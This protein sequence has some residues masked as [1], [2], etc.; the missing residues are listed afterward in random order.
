MNK[1]H[2][3][4][5]TLPLTGALAVVIILFPLQFIDGTP[6]LLAERL[7][8][9]GGYFQIMI[10]A[11]F[12]FFM[13]KNMLNPQKTGWWRR[14]SWTLFSAVFFG[15]LLLGI[16]VDRIF[17]MTGDLHLPVPAMIISGPVYRGELSVMTLI[18][19]SAVVLSGPAW[20]SQYCYFGAI[21]SAFAGRKT[22]SKKRRY[23]MTLK[24]TFLFLAAA[25]ALLLRLAGAERDTALIAGAITGGAGLIIIFI[26]SRSTGK[27]IHCSVWCPVGTLV[28]YLKYINPFRMKIKEGCSRCMK[29][30]SSC[31][32]DALAREDILALKPG[33]TCTL[34]GDCITTCHSSSIIYTFPGMK[35]LN[36]RRFYIT[37][38]VVI[39]SLVLAMARI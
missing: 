25:V 1:T 8:K 38:T 37:L 14:F 6:M 20:C 33:V 22:A 11:L 19:L 31:R 18:F 17:L 30:S 36:A 23:R 9:G 27:M 16:F 34:C 3:S 13:V 5:L 12:A 32:Y 35:P 15:Q 39:Y 4:G 10:I 24:F 28:C 21:D 26:W 7:I 29:C 2:L